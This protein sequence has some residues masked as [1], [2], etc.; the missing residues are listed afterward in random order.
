MSGDQ[1][2]EARLMEVALELAGISGELRE[3][4]EIESGEASAL[5]QRVTVDP[6]NNPWRWKSKAGMFHAIKIDNPNAQVVAVS[7]AGDGAATPGNGAADELVPA[8]S[9]RIIV[10][11]FDVVEIGFDPAVIP[12]GVTKLYVTIYARQLQPASYAFV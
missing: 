11:P 3:L 6:I 5:P 10:R 7:F 1:A 4:I 2:V 12:A 8:H 9:G